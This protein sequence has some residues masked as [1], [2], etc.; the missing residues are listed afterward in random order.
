VEYPGLQDTQIYLVE[1]HGKK[2]I[3]GLGD[4]LFEHKGKEYKEIAQKYAIVYNKL[5]L[6]RIYSK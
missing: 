4:N 5:L 1:M 2:V 6:E 3:S